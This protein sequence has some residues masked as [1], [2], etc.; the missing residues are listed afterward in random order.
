MERQTKTGG[1]SVKLNRIV[2]PAHLRIV[3]ASETQPLAAEEAAPANTAAPPT[4]ID[5]AADP[6]AEDTVTSPLKKLGYAA[7][8]LG[9]MSVGLLVTYLSTDR[10]SVAAPPML[11]SETVEVTQIQPTAAVIVSPRPTVEDTS[12]VPP[13][14][15]APVVAAPTMAP[16]ES[17]AE[18]SRSIAPDVTLA[19]VAP[20]LGGDT[21]AALLLDP[22][23]A[24]STSAPGQ[25]T[26]PRPGVSLVDQVALGTLSAL[27]NGAPASD[28]TAI[29]SFVRGLA[30]GDRSSAEIGAMLQ[31]AYDAGTLNVPDRF[32]TAQGRVDATALLNAIEAQR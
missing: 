2:V 21:G 31:R 32:L 20:V 13:L 23:P 14:D 4:H 29:F 27:R 11:L 16:S 1:Q 7:L 26:A 24:A 3:P 19:R 6:V 8:A 22:A 15:A 25:I 17:G 18:T 28:D 10:D 30:S 5:M 12:P 9:L